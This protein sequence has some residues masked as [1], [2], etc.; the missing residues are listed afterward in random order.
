MNFKMTKGNAYPPIINR[1]MGIKSG[2]VDIP[3]I[4]VDDEYKGVILL[5]HDFRP[6]RN[7]K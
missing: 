2:K 3:Q 7:W 6:A 5:D 1:Q 4:F